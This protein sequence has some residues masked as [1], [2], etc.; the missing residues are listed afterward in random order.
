MRFSEESPRLVVCRL[1]TFVAPSARACE[2][3]SSG[4]V[5]RN[6]SAA[7]RALPV[8]TPAV[9]R[10]RAVV[11]ASRSMPLS[12]ES[13]R[14]RSPCTF[15]VASLAGRM[16]SESGGRSAAPTFLGSNCTPITCLYVV[17]VSSGESRRTGQR[18]AAWPRRVKAIGSDSN[19]ATRALARRAAAVEIAAGVGTVRS[20]TSLRSAS[21]ALVIA[22]RAAAG[23]KPTPA[24]AGTAMAA[25]LGLSTRRAS[26]GACV[27][28][29]SSTGSASRVG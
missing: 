2:V 12:D 16:Y 11:C 8:C 15:Q 7:T 18:P 27:T 24:L 26:T 6:A 29:A 20:D 22:R 19:S 17:A 13:T 5:T 21:A 1:T 25:P 14:A 28:F 4:C 9:V 3:V 23:S 10:W